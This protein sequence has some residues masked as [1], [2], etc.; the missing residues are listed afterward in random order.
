MLEAALGALA[1]GG[2]IGSVLQGNSDE[3]AQRELLAR[4]Q[5]YI[6][7]Y[8]KSMQGLIPEHDLKQ[9]GVLNKL[10]L[11]SQNYMNSPDKVANWLNPNMDYQMGE[12]AKMNNHQY[13]AGGNMLSGAAMKALQDR[14]QNVARM[15]WQDAFNNMNASNSQGLGQANTL[16]NLRLDN[17]SNVFN[18]NA[19]MQSNIL[20]GGLGLA[21]P[22]VNNGFNSFMQG[23]TSGVNA[24]AKLVNAF[25]GKDT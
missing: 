5:G 3:K 22:K 20:N 24:G 23:T 14:G 25:R 15:S 1:L 17:N 13:A 16:A 7:D 9:Q 18:A 21:A 12:I 4:Q 8:E 2:G 11:D 19:G 6:K 10:A